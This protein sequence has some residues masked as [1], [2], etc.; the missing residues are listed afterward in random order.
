MV[1]APAI[2]LPKPAVEGAISREFSGMEMTSTAQYKSLLKAPRAKLATALLSMLCSLGVAHAATEVQMAVDNDSAMC[3]HFRKALVADHVAT[4]TRDQLCQYNFAQKHASKGNGYFQRL[5]WQPVP[6]DPVALTMKIFD[7]NHPPSAEP[8]VKASDRA[9]RADVLSYA[10]LQSRNQALSVETAP[11]S[12]T[13]ATVRGQLVHVNGYVLSSRGTYCG[14]Y[15][16]DGLK[17]RRL[18][19]AF[20]TDK[21]L[22]HSLPNKVY[23]DDEVVEPIEI[24]GK[25]YQVTIWDDAMWSTQHLP[26]I[27]GMF[28]ISLDQLLINSDGSEAVPADICGFTYIKRPSQHVK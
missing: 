19:I 5:N 16:D 17:R 7:A 12:A 26:G 15:D 10:E 27:S 9:R 20:Y 13:K 21:M 1:D 18:S 2:T 8:G 3:E 23:L 28:L 4:M 14:K 24:R 11:F 22:N 25:Y 6:G